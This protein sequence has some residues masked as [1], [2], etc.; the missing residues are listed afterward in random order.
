M[1]KYYRGAKP[2]F[3]IHIRDKDSGALTAPDT[4]PTIQIENENGKVITAWTNMTNSATGIYYYNSL[5]ISSSHTA[6]I[7]RARV[8]V[9]DGTDVTCDEGCETEFEVMGR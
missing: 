8:K 6:G 2:Y 3:E 1:K 5:T 4:A 7:Y 9:T